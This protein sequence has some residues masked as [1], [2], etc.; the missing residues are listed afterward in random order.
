MK[1]EEL[2]YDDFINVKQENSGENLTVAEELNKITDKVELDEEVNGNTDDNNK[3]KTKDSLA[4]IMKANL[5]VIIV[6]ILFVIAF[7]KAYTTQLANK[8]EDSK[9]V[10]V[11]VGN[12]N[13]G[14]NKLNND[15]KSKLDFEKMAIIGNPVL[16]IDEAEKIF[17]VDGRV[18]DYDMNLLKTLIPNRKY[19]HYNIDG[20][21]VFMDNKGLAD[22]PINNFTVYNEKFEPIVKNAK[23]FDLKINP[24]IIVIKTE[25][26]TRLYTYDFRNYREYP[27]GYNIIDI[28]N[29]NDIFKYIIEYEV[30]GIK[31]IDI[32]D[33]YFN[34]RPEIA[35]LSNFEKLYL[36][37]KT[38]FE[39]GD[40]K[41]YSGNKDI[42][43]D[44]RTGY[45]N[46]AKYAGTMNG[47]KFGKAYFFEE[48]I[49][50]LLIT[51]DNKYQICASSL[52]PLKLFSEEITI[53]EELGRIFVN[54]G[55]I[56]DFD[57]NLLK[58]IYDNKKISPII[59]NYQ[60]KDEDGYVNQRNRVYYID[61]KDYNGNQFKTFNIYDCD[62]NVI[63]DK[64]S[65]VRVVEEK[66]IEIT[67]D[68]KTKMYSFD[69]WGDLIKGK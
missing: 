31:C 69:L 24:N 35:G 36:V 62:F 20:K 68:G 61:D 21:F 34:L 12:D 58:K 57:I 13:F 3:D 49:L 52:K 66:G 29:G 22:E 67:K 46:R 26:G 15:K 65:N 11:N 40:G 9:T 25:T 64:V 39:I 41:R 43:Y 23:S 44:V 5:I 55:D 38:G 19:T 1:D 27:I 42:Y 63:I 37:Y 47:N 18:Y 8:K 4:D 6:I 16:I 50:I 45:E 51:K 28:R 14:E 7:A 30:N 53:N 59:V 17:F 60:V 33:G 32:S 54:N 48:K 10:I 56:Y 2:K